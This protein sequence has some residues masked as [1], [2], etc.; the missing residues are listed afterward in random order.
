MPKQDPKYQARYHERKRAEGWVRLNVWVPE[1][2]KEEIRQLVEKR[3]KR[4]VKT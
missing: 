4:P 3:L 1:E 2:R